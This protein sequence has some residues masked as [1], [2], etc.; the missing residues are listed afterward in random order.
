MVS[1]LFSFESFSESDL[2]G[3]VLMPSPKQYDDISLALGRVIDFCSLQSITS[4]L[5]FLFCFR[6]VS[7]LRES[8]ETFAYASS[9]SSFSSSFDEDAGVDDDA[10]IEEEIDEDE[11]NFLLFLLVR[12]S[13]EFKLL[14]LLLLLDLFRL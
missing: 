13:S 11:R 2:V 3:R 7:D 5:F 12:D 10:D 14:V 1:S 8:V 9:S 6:T 4:Y